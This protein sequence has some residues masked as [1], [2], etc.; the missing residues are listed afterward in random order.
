MKA[1]ETVFLL[2]YRD[3]KNEGNKLLRYVG[4]YV[5]IGTASYLRS[6]KGAKILDETSS[7]AV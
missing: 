4:K 2:G 6:L 7:M 1:T 3:T 5:P